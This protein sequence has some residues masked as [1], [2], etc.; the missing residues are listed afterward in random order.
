MIYSTAAQNRYKPKSEKFHTTL[1]ILDTPA[2]IKMYI[3]FYRERYM[4]VVYHTNQ[5]HNRHK[6]VVSGFRAVSATQ[7]PGEQRGEPLGW[8]R[9]GRG[10]LGGRRWQT[11]L[12]GEE[13]L[14][15]W[16]GEIPPRQPRGGKSV[17]WRWRTVKQ[18]RRGK[19]LPLS[20][21]SSA[22]DPP[23]VF[24]PTLPA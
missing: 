13:T 23:P 9:R 22:R 20:P 2:D 18:G 16:A 17:T 21:F 15:L 3:R 5:L 14:L 10:E 19:S 7:S 24:L 12:L 6:A 11:G 4:S 8:R 1:L